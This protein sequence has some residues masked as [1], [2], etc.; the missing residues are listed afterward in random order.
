M[1]LLSSCFWY[2]LARRGRHL[3]DLL[4]PAGVRPFVE[5]HLAVDRFVADAPHPAAVR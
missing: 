5:T 2:F 3:A 1:Q 4:G